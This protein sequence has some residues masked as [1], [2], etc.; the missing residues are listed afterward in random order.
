MYCCCGVKKREGWVCECDWNGWFLCWEQ[1]NKS[2]HS[3][4]VPVPVKEI[5]D[6]D[7]IY[8][9]RVFDDGDDSET[10]SE[11]SLIP[12]NWGEYT[13]QS[14]SNW[15]IKYED[16]YCGFRAVYAWKEW[17]DYSKLRKI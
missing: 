3:I 4:P 10:E 17:D 6:K 12:K 14:I 16:G 8:E 2:V 13:N 5:P 7:G 1:T 15:K 9:V 11:F